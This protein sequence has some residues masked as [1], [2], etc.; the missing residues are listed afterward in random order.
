MGCEQNR[1][2]QSTYSSCLGI[3]NF[4]PSILDPLCQLILFVLSKG[5][6]GLRLHKKTAVQYCQFLPPPT[7]THTQLFTWERRGRIVT[8][9]C[10][11]ITGTDVLVTSNPLASAT[12]VLERTMSSVVTPNIL[13]E[14]IAIVKSEDEEKNWVLPVWI[15]AASL[16]EHL[17]GNRDSGV[18]GISDNTDHGIRTVPEGQGGNI[19]QPLVKRPLWKDKMTTNFAHASTRF[20]TIEAFVLKRSSRVIPAKWDR[21]SKKVTA[22]QIS[23]PC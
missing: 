4:C 13:K 8:P 22:F 9:E 18:H 21:E 23:S 7:T 2:S 11:P 5:H 15:V 6:C 20:F 3:H 19:W 12:K 1:C 17:W 16:L 14:D 10:P